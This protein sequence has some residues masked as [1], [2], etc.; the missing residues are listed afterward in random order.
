M[1]FHAQRLP[2]SRGRP[3]ASPDAPTTCTRD[4]HAPAMRL[5]AT[6]TLA[7][8]HGRSHDQG[9]SVTHG[10]TSSGGLTREIAFRAP[11]IWAP[12]RGRER[13]EKRGPGREVQKE[14]WESGIAAERHRCRAASLPR[15]GHGITAGGGARHRCR[16][17]DSIAAGVED[18]ITAGGAGARHR[19]R[20]GGRR[21]RCRGQRARH[22][23]RGQRARHRCRGRGGHGIAA[24]RRGSPI[25]EGTADAHHACE[26]SV[27]P[28]R[29]H[30]TIPA[31]ALGAPAGHA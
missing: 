22:R 7:D 30:C 8:R 31:P 28:T 1:R 12:H 3:A 25:T 27:D 26:A 10:G 20:G 11:E 2:T 19:C 14:R 24:G 21:H 16:G 17:G 18:G 4:A 13:R 29:W 9:G 6:S 5:G 15:P 23:C